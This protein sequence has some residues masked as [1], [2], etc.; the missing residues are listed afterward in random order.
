MSDVT[1]RPMNGEEYADWYPQAVVEYADDHIRAGSM[2]AEKALELATKQFAE[3]LPDGLETAEHHLLVGTAGD[4][5]VGMLWLNIAAKGGSVT[6][7]VYDVAVDADQRGKGYGRSMMVGAETYARDHGA[8]T[9]K[10]HVFGDNTVA[11][12]LYDSLGYVA[13]NINMAK[14]LV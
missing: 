10:L 2:P 14:P 12:S 4:E 11:R 3:L 8:Q 7:F 1:L 6:A 9:I 5:R 13:T